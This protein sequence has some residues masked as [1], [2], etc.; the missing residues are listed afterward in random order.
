MR[1]LVDAQVALRH[2]AVQRVR[3]PLAQEG[4]GRFA[5]A[6]RGAERRDRHHAVRSDP[7]WRARCQRDAYAISGAADHRH[8]AVQPGPVARP[9]DRRRRADGDAR[10]RLR[11]DPR[12]A[13]LQCRGLPLVPKRRRHIQRHAD[14]R[15]RPQRAGRCSR[16]RRRPHGRRGRRR[17]LGLGGAARDARSEGVVGPSRAAPITDARCMNGAP[18][19]GGRLPAPLLIDGARCVRA[20]LSAAAA[21]HPRVA[22]SPRGRAARRCLAA[23]EC[24]CASSANG[25]PVPQRPARAHSLVRR[26]ARIGNFARCAFSSCSFQR[27]TEPVILHSRRCLRGAHVAWMEASA[28]FGAQSRALPACPALR[29]A[30]DRHALFFTA[31]RACARRCGLH[32]VCN[33]DCCGV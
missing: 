29:R 9:P 22:V 21:R 7:R 10:P 3:P 17:R 12:R 31:P 23:R 8:A 20:T 33:R 19:I 24:L 27:H 15:G 2:D 30:Q 6:R 14:S 28:R 4:A 11:L 25:S 18:M 16:R 13:R 5:P 1:Y 32:M 26:A